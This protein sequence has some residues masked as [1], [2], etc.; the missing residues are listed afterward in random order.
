MQGAVTEL[1][2]TISQS[3][4][5]YWL[6]IAQICESATMFATPMNAAGDMIAAR[7]SQGTI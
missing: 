4:Q 2:G 1:I 6:K 3:S 7:T 5:F